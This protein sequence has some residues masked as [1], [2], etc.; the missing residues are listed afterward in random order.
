MS[1]LAGFDAKV[2]TK[3]EPSILEQEFERFYFNMLPHLTDS[4]ARKTIARIAALE[5]IPN[6]SVNGINYGAD[7]DLTAEVEGL[8]QSVR[9]MRN[10][11]MTESGTVKEDVT[12]REMKEVVTSTASL[13]T[14]LMKFHEKLMSFERQRVLEQSTIAI[15]REM[16]GQEIVDRFVEMMEEQLG[17]EE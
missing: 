1:D 12:P 16:G 14:L 8:I 6:S 2:D 10:S 4:M 17:K 3:P 15:L 9:A 11:V 5:L 13:M 7:F